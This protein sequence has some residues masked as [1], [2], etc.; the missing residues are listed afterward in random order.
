MNILVGI[1]GAAAGFVAGIFVYDV[2]GVA[3]KADP[4]ASGLLALFVFG[5]AGAV[6][7]VFLFT[8]LVMRIRGRPT[9]EV[10]TR[11]E[12]VPNS[13]ST[14]AGH[15]AAG[16]NQA[17]AGAPSALA[18]TTPAGGSVAKTGF[19]TIG[20]VIALVAL[21]GSLYY[22]YAVATATPWLNPNAAPVMMQFEIRLAEGVALPASLRDIEA[23][24]VTDLN[25]MPVELQPARFRR[26]GERAVIVG[27][28]DLAFRTAH[29][30][31][32]LAINGRPE[33]TYQIHLTDKAPHTSELG[34][35][36]KHPDGSE[37]RYR[38]KW[39]GRD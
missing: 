19:K 21:A 32:D 17:T 7:G 37:I 33:R 26:D 27:E 9:G 5:P 11:A 30:Q 6:G 13:A 23:E 22:W 4:I 2:L 35:W 34:R 8:W 24:L 36:Q 18:P 15:P 28:V 29:R 16:A 14:S 1:I 12:A 20:I 3:N 25:R 38:A 10:A 39:P 31:I